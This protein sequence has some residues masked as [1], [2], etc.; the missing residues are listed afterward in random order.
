MTKNENDIPEWN[1]SQEDNSKREYKTFEDLNRE[2]LQGPGGIS[3]ARILNENISL[4]TTKKQKT[5]ALEFL[6]DC[7]RNEGDNTIFRKEINK[8][9]YIL[10]TARPNGSNEEK[11]SGKKDEPKILYRARFNYEGWHYAEF[12]DHGSLK[13]LKYRD[14]QTD[15]VL[16]VEITDPDDPDKKISVMPAPQIAQTK[17]DRALQEDQNEAVK[18]PPAPLD[19]G[20]EYDLYRE[21]KAFIHAF[22]ELKPEDEI[23][24]SL[25]VMKAAVFDALKDT[26]F[27]FIHILAPYGKGKSRLLT[28]MCEITPY[29]FY[30]VDIKSA[31]LKRV[32]DLYGVVLYVDEKGSMDN[33]LAAILNGK[34]NANALI[35]NANNEIQQGFSAIIGYRIFGPL[36]MAG[37][38]PFR[39]DAIES[40]SFQVNLDFEL[41]REDVPRKIKGKLLDDFRERSQIIRGKLL[42]FRVKWHDRINDLPNS[43]FLK[44]Y[45]DHTEP[46][47]FEVI[48]FFEDLIE[49]IPE[50]KPEIGEVLKT[51]IIRN[52][53]VAAQT[54]NGIIANEVLALM[55]SEE[56]KEE[57]VINGKSCMGIY[58]SA[59]YDEIGKDYAKQ[60]GKILSALGLKT[61]RPRITKTREDRDGNKQE[62]TKRYSMVRIP[63][64]KKEREL[65]SRYDPDFVIANLSSIEQGPQTTLDDEDDEDDDLGKG[66]PNF[67]NKNL[68]THKISGSEGQNNSSD[69]FEYSE[70]VHAIHINKNIESEK[71]DKKNDS[72]SIEKLGEQSKDSEKT[73]TPFQNDSPHRPLSPEV[74]ADQVKS[75]VQ[76]EKPKSADSE[77]PGISEQ[78]G[79][80]LIE[81]LRMNDYLT[82]I[83]SG[84]SIDRKLF[85]IGFTK[86][87]QTTG[88]KLEDIKLIMAKWK[89]REAST[90]Q[91]GPLW[92]VRP[93][94]RDRP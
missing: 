77:D 55:Q 83:D 68:Q 36:V 42:Q 70:D 24:L 4:I 57:Y 1:N 85:K 16:N 92:F 53:E 59:I 74:N 62:Y 35:L 64:E 86:G 28:V 58:L 5:V 52:V 9:Q 22:M 56:G 63:D 19:Y 48:S 72:T 8:I 27:P 44:L 93:I 43:D 12:S 31:A 21:I 18:F 91:Y 61:D 15:V 94:R 71:N 11:A 26:S 69:Q 51:Q 81:T 84:L 40:K 39:D 3:G 45:E 82:D 65:R 33:D 66:T 38:S 54:P 7:L 17:R 47:L 60:T 37:R 89:F 2:V 80:V 25:Y 34:Y 76:S 23:I 14:D 10:K 13:F 6:E 67:N 29:G 87:P 73:D 49:I 32:S 88:E 30:S 20:S 79:K 75:T 90:G 78:E 46:R 41:S 50:I